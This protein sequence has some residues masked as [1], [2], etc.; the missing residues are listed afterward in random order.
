MN[1]FTTDLERDL[2]YVAVAEFLR[3]EVPEAERPQEGEL[4][5]FSETF[6]TDIGDVVTAFSNTYGGLVILGVGQK[7]HGQLAVP[8]AIT[9]LEASKGEM[10]SRIINTILTTVQP[11]PTFSAGVVSL[12]NNS[13]R[14]IAVIRVEQGVDPPYMFT[15]DHRNK[16]SVRIGDSNQP[17]SLEQLRMLFEK[18]LRGRAQVSESLA[19]IGDPYVTTDQGVRS[20]SFLLVVWAPVSPIRIR[21]DR[22]T[23]RSFEELIRRF[24]R[25]RDRRSELEQSRAATYTDF[26]T[27]NREWDYP[28]K[29]R[30]TD[31]G[32]LAFITKIGYI[33]Y[34][35]VPE[36]TEQRIDRLGNWIVDTLS[37]MSLARQWSMKRGYFGLGEMTHTMSFIGAEAILQVATMPTSD[38]EGH[39]EMAGVEAPQPIVPP[40]FPTRKE[41]NVALAQLYREDI[42]DIVAETFLH[43][44]RGVGGQVDWQKLSEQIRY[45]LGAVESMTEVKWPAT[46]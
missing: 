37:F 20:G 35:V 6:P 42:V 31:A 5:D 24:Y 22:A 23:E 9:G 2:T 46:K 1:L 19:S 12:E 43:H 45:L 28:R 39:V 30:I 4:L 14:C 8:S 38:F 21:L 25:P 11:R 17:A 26:D 13:G 44:L 40:P 7:K 36:V 41:Y 29:W 18:G 32:A 34:P 3:L 15:R 27:Y 10:R 16:V 33:P